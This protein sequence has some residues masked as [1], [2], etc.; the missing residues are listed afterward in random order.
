[1]NASD[2]SP[3]VCED[4]PVSDNEDKVSRM[5][6]NVFGLKLP[7]EMFSLAT[8]SSTELAQILHEYGRA[9]EKPKRS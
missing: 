3:R 1:M 5:L 7:N 8:R 9:V 2:G 4:T 6:V